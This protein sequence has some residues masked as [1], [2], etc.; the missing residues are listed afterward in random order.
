MSQM[1]RQIIIDRF[2]N[3]R[4]RGELTD[5]DIAHGD[6]NVSCGDKLTFFIKLNENKEVSE[7][8]Y[9][10]KGCTISLASADLLAESLEE[11]TLEEIEE[12]D[13]E[14]VMDLLGIPVTPTRTKCAI[15]GLKIVQAGVNL[16]NKVGKEE[17]KTA[18][19]EKGE[20]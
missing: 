9:E 5:P 4:Y 8:R 18:L 20:I 11:M 3:P 15:L 14:F 1:Y 10:G 16:Y 2:K 12:L 7:I 13:N 17:A 6:E 19:R